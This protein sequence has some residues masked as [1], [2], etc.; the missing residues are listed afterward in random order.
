MVIL[1]TK[2]LSKEEQDDLATTLLSTKKVINVAYKSQA[3][4]NASNMLK[5][6][7]SVVIILILL[8]SMLSF[9]VLYNLSNINIQERKREIATLKVLGF[10]NKEVDNYITKE[11]IIITIFGIAIG[12]FAGYFLTMVTLSTVEIEA[13]RFIRTIEPIS[14]LYAS[15]LTIVFTII[16]NI[17]A[18]FNLKRINMVES[19]KSVE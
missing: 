6:L 4:D 7:N 9:I 8:A 17:V 15:I 16:V 19:L 2:E 3:K 11:N 18:H 13:A 14:Y 10:Y 12:L 1:K 5:S